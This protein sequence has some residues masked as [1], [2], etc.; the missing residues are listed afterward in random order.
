MFLPMKQRD[1]LRETGLI[2][3]LL[4][5]IS[6]VVSPAV[7]AGIIYAYMKRD[8]VAGTFVESHMTWLIRTFWLTLIGSL[9]GVALSIV[10]VG[11]L[12]LGLVWLWFVYRVVKGFVVFND[13][14]PIDD[15]QAWF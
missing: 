1:T 13:G 7:I 14:Q 8:A 15:A 12:L 3:Y 2:A 10:V 11:I 6:I 5:G 9:V 4:Y